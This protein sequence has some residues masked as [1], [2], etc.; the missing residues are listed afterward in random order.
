[1]SLER[2]KTYAVLAITALFALGI[3]FY[4]RFTQPIQQSPPL[5]TAD[6]D[7]VLGDPN[8]PITIIEFSDYQCPFCRKFYSDTFE[9]LKKNY[10]DT[11]KAKLVFRDFPLTIHPAA[12]SAAE[13]AECVRA[14]GGDTA[15]WD[16]HNTLFEEQNKQD[17]GDAH[18]RVTKTIDFTQQ[19]LITWAATLG[20][21]IEGCLKT[22][23]FTREVQRDIRDGTAAGVVDAP[24]FFINGQFIAGAQPFSTFQQALEL[25]Q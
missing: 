4:A 8:A 25:S 1:M 13:A 17:S 21:D 24:T 19:D 2:S 6:N 5:V 15:Y 22:G 12:Q 3:F 10:L 16:M 20:Y 23:A 11:G 7:P 14:Q 9:Q 18:G